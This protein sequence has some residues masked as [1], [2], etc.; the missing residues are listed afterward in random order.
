MPDKSFAIRLQDELIAEIRQRFPNFDR[1]D[2]RKKG[3]NSEIL[4]ELIRTGL[5]NDPNQETRQE[6]AE[7]RQ[8]LRDLNDSLNEHRKNLSVVL[9]LV[10][11]NSGAPREQSE[12]IIE[13]LQEK[14]LLYSW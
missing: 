1:P 12:R 6:L 2:Q 9:E 4:R 11:R 3:E 10:L 13:A 5:G 8:G 14:G 7:T